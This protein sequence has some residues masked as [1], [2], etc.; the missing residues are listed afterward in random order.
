MK[1]K[2]LIIGLLASLLGGCIVVPAH[3]YAYHPVPRVYVY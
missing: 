3:P 1:T 2:L